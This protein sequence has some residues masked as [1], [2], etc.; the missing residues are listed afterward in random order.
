MALS[1]T[2]QMLLRKFVNDSDSD[3]FD[4]GGGG[5]ILPW[6]GSDRSR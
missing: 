4:R 3:C 1:A 6:P 2:R 5:L